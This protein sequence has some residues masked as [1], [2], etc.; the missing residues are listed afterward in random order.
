[1][2]LN[3]CN[4]HFW[5]F[6]ALMA[7]LTKQSPEVVARLGR[8]RPHDDKVVLLRPAD[9]SVGEIRSYLER[10]LGFWRAFFI[11][12]T[13]ALSHFEQLD[14]V[15]CT[16]PFSI[17]ETGRFTVTPLGCRYYGIRMKRRLQWPLA[18][19]ATKRDQLLAKE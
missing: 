10:E 12:I 2:K 6:G 14:V 18:G 5:V 3:F 1:M 15:E 9:V 16:K 19:P 7:I 13:D 11:N 8:Y 4:A 17:D